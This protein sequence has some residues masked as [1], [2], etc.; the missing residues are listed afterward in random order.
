MIAAESERNPAYTMLEARAKNAA[1]TRRNTTLIRHEDISPDPAQPRKEFSTSALEHLAGTIRRQG[2][3]Q[4]LLLRPD[5]ADTER[6][7]IIS[8][9]RRWRAAQLAELE[10]LPAVVKADLDG[11][12]IS[13]V[14]LIE[15]L[16]RQNL[17]EFEETQA[18]LKLLAARLALSERETK[19]L[20]S[21]RF[22]GNSLGAEADAIV[23]D[24]LVLLGLTLK[25]FYAQR[26]PLLDLDEA[27]VV[28]INAGRLPY[29]TA[30]LLQRISDPE[31]RLA[32]LNEVL[33]L[34]LSRQEV[35]K[36]LK[37]LQDKATSNSNSD[38]T[39]LVSL[40]KRWSSLEGERLARAQALLAELEGLLG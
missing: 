32:L 5:P 3:L 25:S 10:W 1:G 26:L 37:T 36:R 8:G 19:V 17:S 14:Q 11:L 29:S 15:N 4:P 20:L 13:E 18:A 6:Y 38:I 21:K 22:K 24:V 33:E 34:G 39:R 27:L 28:A 9:E 35:E 40:K 7:L 30:R 12:E 16:E 31:T 23:D 2:I